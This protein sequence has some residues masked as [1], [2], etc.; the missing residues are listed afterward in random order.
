MHK[1]VTVTVI[2]GLITFSLSFTVISGDELYENDVCKTRDGSAG[3]CTISSKCPWYV[4]N[5]I[6]RR[7]I[8]YRHVV[9][10]GFLRDDEIICCPSEQTEERN[11]EDKSDSL[12]T[13]TTDRKANQACRHFRG[14]TKL[15][16]HIVEG[17]DAEE[18]DVPF[19][20]ALGYE[21][22]E[23]GKLYD[24]GCG[25]SLISPRFLL[26]AAHCI[27]S[28][29][30]P[31]VARM[32]TLSLDMPDDPRAI[33]DSPLKNFY[34]H[35]EYTPRY[36]YN[37]IALIEVTIPFKY[38]D[39]VNRVCLETK[40]ADLPH[41]QILIASGWGLTGEGDPCSLRDNSNGYCIEATKCPWFLETIV[42]KKKF[43]ERVTCGFDGKIEVICCKSNGTRPNGL[44]SGIRTRLAC[45]QVP[46]I[47]SRLT[48]HIIDGVEAEEGEFPFMAALGY[49]S[50]E[51][52]QGYDYRC[53]ASLISENFLLTAAHCI[54]KQSRPVVALL[55]T[56]S[57]D[58]GNMGVV[59][60]IKEFYPHPDYR[61]SRSYN[62][63][64]LIELED[65]L[66]NEPNVNPICVYSGT[67][68][69]S[70]SVVLTAEGF[71]ITD[72]DRQSRSSTL[73]KVNLTTVAL[74]KCNQTFAENNLLTN[75]RRLSLG[76]IE[77]QYCATGIENTVT[78]QIGDTCQGD[79]GGPLQIVENEKFKLIGVTSFGNGCGS[80][81][82]SVYTRVSRYIDWIESVVWPKTP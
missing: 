25:S 70:E 14:I 6:R 31:V 67:E 37:D 61:T 16:Y 43:N 47:T 21:S 40:P 66:M 41:T 39:N 45:D 26:T 7:L 76:L 55:G 73:M 36:K 30:R 28:S 69:L 18:G 24:W 17:E 75:N 20:A 4:S 44:A 27:R 62:D 1:L 42:K 82:P 72:V 34:P 46:P 51:I 38:D 12:V 59:V 49:E 65:K 52:E 8:P 60:R 3:I 5:V 35:P 56:N 71:G 54:P 15:T 22:N 58:T 2:S 10:C 80:N 63:I 50:E 64:A 68:D 74:D 9:R 19:I 57:L 81:T 11:Q 29:R 79:S 53:G 13:R 23:P 33:Q 32:G 48:F 77:T 78:K